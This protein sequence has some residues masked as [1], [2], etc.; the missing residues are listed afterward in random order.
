MAKGDSGRI[1]IEVD[2]ALKRR[3]YSEL[4]SDGSTL[5]AWFVDT[6]ICYL[7]EKEQP[8][9]PVVAQVRKPGNGL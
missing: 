5:K 8:R 2:P 4:A 1:V 7:D 3:L 9:L 6:A